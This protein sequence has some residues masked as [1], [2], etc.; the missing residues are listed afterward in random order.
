M[1]TTKMRRARYLLTLFLFSIWI[2]GCY[3]DYGMSIEDFDLVT[4]FY[5]NETDFSAI[6]SY[7]LPDTV[8]HIVSEEED[9]DDINRAYDPHILQQINVNMQTLGYEKRTLEDMVNGRRPDVVLL[10]AVT[11]TKN[12][13]WYPGYP[14]YPGWGYWPGWGYYPGGPGGGWYFPPYWSSTSYTTGSLLIVMLDPDETDF[15]EEEIKA[16]WTGGVNGLLNE[17][18][19]DIRRRLTYSITEVFRISPY[20]GVSENEM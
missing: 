11:S 10:V 7:A 1:K 9:E 19:E 20:L 4:A 6:A 15:E 8:F 14:G 5:D 17:K 3:R 18:S 16:V 12:S 2:A 13:V